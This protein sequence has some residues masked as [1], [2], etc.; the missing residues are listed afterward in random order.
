MKI[1]KSRNQREGKF[2]P[3]WC[4]NPPYRIGKTDPKT[5]ATALTPKKR[6]GAHYNLVKVRNF[7]DGGYIIPGTTYIRLIRQGA[8]E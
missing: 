8:F 4:Y 3:G 5:G 7:N 6:A 1:I 2:I